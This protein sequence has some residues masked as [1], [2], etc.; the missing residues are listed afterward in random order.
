MNASGA[1][2]SF[3]FIKV[4]ALTELAPD[5]ST[6]L[7]TACRSYFTPIINTP[8][9]FCKHFTPTIS[10]NFF[11]C[12][13]N[14]FRI[15]IH[16]F[17]VEASGTAP[18]SSLF[19]CCFNVNSLFITQN[20]YLVNDYCSPRRGICPLHMLANIAKRGSFLFFSSIPTLST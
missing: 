6:F 1:K 18:E 8:I 2:L 9:I 15:F 17:M 7:I 20:R 19:S 3:A 4:L 11:I 5:D 12:F 16:V 10:V 13:C 14:F